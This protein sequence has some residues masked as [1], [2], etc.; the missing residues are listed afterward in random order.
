MNAATVQKVNSAIFITF[1]GHCKQAL[2]FYQTCFGGLLELDFLENE[3]HGYTEIPIVSG[4]LVSD[5]VVIRGSDLVHNEGRKIGNYMAIYI[6]C[7]D[8]EERF[9]LIKKLELGKTKRF[10]SEKSVSELI[11]ITDVFGVRWV[12]G[13]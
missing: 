3:L 12:L 1:S 10:Y 2:K 8:E 5:R 7:A 4:L 11:E 13:I 6:Q 9:E